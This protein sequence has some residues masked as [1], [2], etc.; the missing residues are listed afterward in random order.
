[1]K[2]PNSERSAQVEEQRFHPQDYQ[3]GL[4]HAIQTDSAKLILAL[5]I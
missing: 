3:E 2:V 1:M 4:N 5:I